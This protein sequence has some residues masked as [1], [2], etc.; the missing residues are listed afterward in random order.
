MQNI[1]FSNNNLSY[2]ELEIKQ[3]LTLFVKIVQQFIQD[4]QSNSKQLQ[5]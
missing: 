1:T 3:L 5:D 4:F 2:E